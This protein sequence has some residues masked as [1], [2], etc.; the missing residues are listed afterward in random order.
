MF[1]QKGLPE[2]S[3]MTKRSWIVLAALLFVSGAGLLYVTRGDAQAPVSGVKEEPKA[4]VPDKIVYGIFFRQSAAFKAKADDIERD[5]GDGR[6][7]RNH[8]ARIAGLDDAQSELL[9][10]VVADYIREANIISAR[11]K[12]MVD[13]FHTQYPGGQIPNGEARERPPSFQEL[14][15]ERERLY[16]RMRDQLQSVLGDETFARLDTALRSKIAANSQSVL[17]EAAQ[18]KTEANE[19]E[20]P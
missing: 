12:A 4:Q 10:K 5:V 7:L 8:L 6:S 20:I 14:N 9:D 17:D 18:S 16:L 11:Q 15:L 1:I 3:H 2:R 13:A 19:Q